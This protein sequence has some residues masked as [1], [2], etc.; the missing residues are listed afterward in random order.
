MANS[1]TK[2]TKMKYENTPYDPRINPAQLLYAADHWAGLKADG[3]QCEAAMFNEFWFAPA[4]SAII[5]SKW[6]MVAVHDIIV[7]YIA[8][9]VC[10]LPDHTC[11]VIS[12]VR[13]NPFVK[14][15]DA[16]IRRHFPDGPIVTSNE[17]DAVKSCLSNGVMSYGL[18]NGSLLLFVPK[19]FVIG[20]ANLTVSLRLNTIVSLGWDFMKDQEFGIIGRLTKASPEPSWH[21]L[22]CNRALIFPK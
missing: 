3:F 1:S 17:P 11:I 18:P 20:E 7:T 8:A 21:P 5:R 9:R 6:D 10:L 4:E 14:M 13:P 19:S 16:H 12:E 22:H 2:D 15:I